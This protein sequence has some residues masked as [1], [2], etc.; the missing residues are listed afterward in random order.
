MIIESEIITVDKP[1]VLPNGTI[2]HRFSHVLEGAEIGR[3][4]MIG[5]HCYISRDVKIGD[6]TRIQNGNNIYDGCEI[7]KN[8]FIAPRVAMSNHHDPQI[9]DGIFVPD[10]IIIGDGAILCINCTII[11]P[12]QIGR[13]SKIAG[14]AVVL[15]DIADNETYYSLYKDRYKAGLIYPKGK[16]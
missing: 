1:F 15:R 2:I 5:E 13:N 12:C 3:N 9:R 16:K 7:G 11:A 6:G 8:V 10:K 4:C 14:G